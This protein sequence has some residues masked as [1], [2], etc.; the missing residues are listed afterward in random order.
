MFMILTSPQ[1]QLH[2]ADGFSLGKLLKSKNDEQ[3]RI[4]WEKDLASAQLRAKNEQKLLL[5]HFSG[6]HCMPCRIMEKEVFPA[7][8][9]VDVVNMEYVAVKID[10][11]KNPDLVTEYDVKG[12]PVDM[13]F[14]PDGE[15]IH[16]RVGGVNAE[17]YVGELKKVAGD[18]SIAQQKQM[19]K[20]QVA[21]QKQP[22]EQQTVAM[23]SGT[24][25]T[26][27][28][29]KPATEMENDTDGYA[30]SKMPANSQVVPGTGL[31]QYNSPASYRTE[32]YRTHASSSMV[33]QPSLI[34]HSPAPDLPMPNLPQQVESSFQ[35]ASV[36]S[37]IAPPV[38][39][40]A[41]MTGSMTGSMTATPSM[42]LPATVATPVIRET[43]LTARSQTPPVGV[44]ENIVIN[45]PLQTGLGAGTSLG[46]ATIAKNHP[47]TETS[48][49][50]AP[51]A[52]PPNNTSIRQS[53]GLQNMAPLNRPSEQNLAMDGYCPVTLVEI[54]KW[55]KGDPNITSIHEGIAFRFI[56]VEAQQKFLANPE[57]YAPALGGRDIV[58][59]TQSHQNVTGSRKFGAWFQNRIYLFTN[60][61]NYQK[62]QANPNFYAVR[63]LA[64]NP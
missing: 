27:P 16:Q 26:I 63:D 9:V 39:S 32:S 61:D 56:S 12:I 51:A 46:L 20:S 10:T 5:I 54:S 43:G 14:T 45:K 17:Q 19:R 2:A 53:M 57:R 6:D 50:N 59:W 34:V 15:K 24:M 58:E 62:F 13:Y 33:E 11:N 60:E 18:Y 29:N 4:L 21:A 41:T 25:E 1:Q 64:G 8:S 22:V 23:S 42:P 55:A 7:R 49:L 35:L 40:Q 52:L 31:P 30:V 48:A 47:N 37:S 44:F 3:N 28:G 36:P 38:T